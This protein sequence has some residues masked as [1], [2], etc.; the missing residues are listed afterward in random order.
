VVENARRRIEAERTELIEVAPD[1]H[2]RLLANFW[3]RIHDFPARLADV[4]RV[5]ARSKHTIKGGSHEHRCRHSHT[6]REEGRDAAWS[7]FL[8]TGE[9]TKHTSMF[10][11]TIPAGFVTGRHVHRVQEE[12]CY[13]LEGECE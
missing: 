7:S 1:C 5:P 12:T 3:E 2:S 4:A 10:D 9:N 6:R 11:W 8:V 13:L